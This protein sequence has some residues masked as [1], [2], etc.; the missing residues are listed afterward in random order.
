MVET[1]S[2]TLFKSINLVLVQ[3]SVNQLNVGNTLYFWPP[4]TL[5]S[6][7]D[8]WFSLLFCP[9]N[10]WFKKGA[11]AFP[12]PL[13]IFKWIVLS[14]HSCG[15][16]L[17]ID[18]KQTK[19]E[20]LIQKASTVEHVESCLKNKTIIRKKKSVWVNEIV[21]LNMQDTKHRV[22]SAAHFPLTWKLPEH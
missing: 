11:P 19:A 6:N 1:K 15:N 7:K 4:F 18:I 3:M 5:Q 20:T 13:R 21:S 14:D 12:S 16:I 17:N 2:N 9:W 10:I 22:M 8:N